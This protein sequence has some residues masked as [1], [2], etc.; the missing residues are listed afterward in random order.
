MPVFSSYCL[1]SNGPFIDYQL[2]AAKAV[3]SAVCNKDETD[4]D[5]RN[6]MPRTR[7]CRQNF[8]QQPLFFLSFLPTR[9]HTLRVPLQPYTT[10]CNERRWPEN[11]SDWITTY[12]PESPYSDCVRWWQ[13]YNAVKVFW[14]T[15][16]SVKLLGYWTFGHPSSEIKTLKVAIYQALVC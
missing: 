15:Q 4:T 6:L 14:D 5:E 7:S 10:A 11:I 9:L 2:P 1:I 12:M 13:A 8:D 16:E 3:T